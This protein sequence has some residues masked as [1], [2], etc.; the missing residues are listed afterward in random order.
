MGRDL[1]RRPFKHYYARYAREAYPAMGMGRELLSLNLG[2]ATL[3]AQPPETMP[4]EARQ[5]F[6]ALGALPPLRYRAP[7]A[8]DHAA[9]PRCAPRGDIP[10][11]QL[12]QM[13]LLHNPMLEATPAE[14]RATPA[15]ER[16]MLR[17][18]KH[19]VTRVAHVLNAAHTRVLEFEE[20]CAH[21]PNLV[22]RGA[23]RACVKRMFET[24]RS[25]LRR[26]RCTLAAGSR[27]EVQQGHF[28]HTRTGQLLRARQ[29][30]RAGDSTVPAWVC[31][32]EP[33]TGAIRVTDEPATLPANAGQ[34][35][36]CPTICLACSDAEETD[37]ED[38]PVA[39]QE[40]VDTQLGRAASVLAAK[41]GV[42][43]HAALGPQ[44][45]PPVPDPRLLEWTVPKTCKPEGRVCLAYSTTKN[46]R[47]TY[48]AQRSVARATL[49]HH[50][51]RH[52]ARWP[53]RPGAPRPPGQ[54]RRGARAPRHPRGGAPPP[55]CHHTPRPLARQP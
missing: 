52:P 40:E 34:S 31:E 7:D 16:E 38:P 28:R 45:A 5:S 48:L 17:W 26:W 11:D 37:D 6:R 9:D 24:I 30:A 12:L 55:V 36:P 2:F 13:P 18:A 47:L 33:Q 20:L 50:K 54:S 49:F 15:E 43:R 32:T 51:A 21:R 27:P 14:R 35:E 46:V 39:G 1:E 10:H 4:G 25:N 44:G 23:T 19:G 8:G 29:T 22:G 42:F 41:A 3:L 53:L